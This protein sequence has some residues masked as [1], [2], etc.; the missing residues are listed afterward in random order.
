MTYLLTTPYLVKYVWL[1]YPQQLIVGYNNVHPV[2]FYLAFLS[3]F[4][5]VAP[6]ESAHGYKNISI[7]VIASSSLVLG[8]YW[9]LNNTAWG[10]FWVND[11]I[12]WMLLLLTMFSFSLLHS[13]ITKQT[14]NLYLTVTVM[15]FF[16]ILLSRYGLVFTRHSFFDLSK[17]VN[18]TFA[19]LVLNARQSAAL[20]LPLF[21]INPLLLF[22]FLLNCWLLID[23][24]FFRKT[25]LVIIHI[26]IL[27]FMLTW[28]QYAPLHQTLKSNF[29]DLLLVTEFNVLST[30]TSLYLLL[31]I[32]F[33]KIYFIVGH[34]FLLLKWVFFKNLLN[35][36]FCGTIYIVILLISITKIYAS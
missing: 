12:E 1:H 28:L 36:L 6:F 22:V 33:V 14:L 15:L 23:L 27:V 26:L 4:F 25:S 5:F 24:Y 7:S 20:F 30:K 9:G 13:K 35:V 11:F 32:S 8:G 18:Y 31:T 29:Y 34:L 19:Y 10:F 2:L 17:S 16:F 21:Y 3:M